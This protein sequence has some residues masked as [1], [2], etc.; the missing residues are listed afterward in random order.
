MNEMW[1]FGLLCFTSFFTLI[2]PLGAM[3]VFMTMTMELEEKQ[4]RKVARKASLVTFLII[5]MFAVSGDLLFRFF[6]ISIDSLRIVGGI[7]FLLMG[8]DMLQARLVKI[9]V[10]ESEVKSYVNDISI[11]PL[12]IPM[13][14]GPGAITN[15][16][17]MWNRAANWE[18]KVMMI[19]AVMIVI[20]LVY[21]ILRSSTR[22]IKMLGETGNNVMMRLMGLIVMV[23]AVEF[24]FSGLK[25]IVI[26]ILKSL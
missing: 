14:C 2:N 6:G 19:V 15:A 21:T 8:M 5:M 16:I 7:I 9:K 12:S 10:K 18:M 13:L 1:A 11:T 26:D 3:P 25:P 17:V 23:I 24:F 22:L 20:T 4:R